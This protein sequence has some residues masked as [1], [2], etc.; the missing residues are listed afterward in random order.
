VSG[1]EQGKV[2]GARRRAG[3]GGV[4]GDEET[5]RERD[6]VKEEENTER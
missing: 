5:A 2:A 6:V 3:E 1:G 4:L